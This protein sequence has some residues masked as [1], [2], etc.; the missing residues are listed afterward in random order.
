MQATVCAKFGLP[1]IIYMGAKDMERQALN[2]FRMRLLGAEVCVGVP[3]HRILYC[4]SCL[5][6]PYV[7]VQCFHTLKAIL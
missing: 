6:L 3:V 1:C 4:S 5:S 7:P 2:V